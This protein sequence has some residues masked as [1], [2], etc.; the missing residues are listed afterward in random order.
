[1]NFI[2]GWYMVQVKKVFESVEHNFPAPGHTYLVCYTDDFGVTERKT[3]ESVAV[4]GPESLDNFV[5]PAK[6]KKPFKAVRMTQEKHSAS[7][8][9]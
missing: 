6:S 7:L 1:M 4:Y 3:K 9:F 8:I 2:F 5:E